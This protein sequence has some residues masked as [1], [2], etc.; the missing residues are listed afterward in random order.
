MRFERLAP[1]EADGAVL[2]HTVRWQ[3]GALRKGIQ[4]DSVAIRR[5]EEAGVVE[6]MAAIAEAGDLPENLA[7]ERLAGAL[8]KDSAHQGFRQ[9]SAS[10]GRCNIFADRPG[11][12]RVL[13]EDVDRL[14]AID[15]AISLATLP[16]LARVSI[17]QLVATV[18]IIPYAVPEST[19]ETAE[20]ILADSAH[21][22]QVRGAAVATAALLLTR[23]PWTPDSL[24]DKLARKG[25]KAIQRR[26][27]ALGVSLA[28]TR[29][30]P[31]VEQPLAEAIA[32]C[33]TDLVLVLGDSATSDRGDVAPSALR[34]AGGRVERF[35]MPVDPGNLLLLG[36]LDDR[37]VL[38]FPG[39]VRSPKLNGAD[40]V[41]ERVV[42]GIPVTSQDIAGMGVGGLLQEIPLRPAPRVGGADR[43]GAPKVAVL[44]LAAGASRRMRGEHKLLRHLDGMPLVARAATRLAGAGE[45]VLVTGHRGE[46]I[47]HAVREAGVQL[48]AVVRNTAHDE[49]IGASIRAGMSAVDSSVDAV[50]VALADMPGM[51][52]AMVDRLVAAYDPD[53]GRAICRAVAPGDS[54]GHP[55]L[56]GRRFFET[57]ATL[58]GDRGAR[59][60]LVENAHLVAD[61][62]I[63]ARAAADLDTIED[64]K[65]WSQGDSDG[66][67]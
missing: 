2:A 12:L 40:W 43:P 18:K 31:H 7:A 66:G 33:E 23:L 37:P 49:G 65:S 55:V 46:E 3:G 48:A 11:V 22:L 27:E 21:V 20:R 1:G 14:N 47:E 62:E 41:L 26:L 24:G 54:V 32:A 59:D 39:C 38:V 5:L 35:G 67:E 51:D 10:T 9:A 64:W 53:G 52:R 63:S 30:V 44:L 50:V 29:T 16:D 8:L 25:E 4:L 13:G 6:V 57:L 34:A 61:L 45:L 60:M 15:E 36:S 28:E 58:S 56:F 17:G 19:V 42:C